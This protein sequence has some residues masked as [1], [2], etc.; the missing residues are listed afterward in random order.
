MA[1]TIQLQDESG[2][3]EE[4]VYDIHG[5]IVERLPLL[6]DQSFHCLRFIDPYGDTYFNGMQMETFLSEWDH[7][8]GS[9]EDKEVKEL[10]E[11]VR[12][13][14]ERCKKEVHLYLKFEGD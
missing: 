4:V 5:Y 13:L 11:R 6:K 14:A 12:A 3:V 10:C 8:F 9:I 1:L 2:E 7:V